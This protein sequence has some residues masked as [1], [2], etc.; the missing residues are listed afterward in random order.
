VKRL[1]FLLF[2]MFVALAQPQAQARAAKPDPQPGVAPMRV[3]IV[4]S[5]EPGCEPYCAEWISA[6]G[7]INAGTPGEFRRAL[8]KMGARN[9]PVF[10]HSGGGLI[11]AALEIGRMLLARKLNI[12]VTGTP[13]RR[14]RRRASRWASPRPS[15]RAALRPARLFWRRAPSGLCRRSVLSACTAPRP[16]APRCA[17]CGDTA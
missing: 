5:D 2:C 11:P 14:G 15:T 1:L 4:R 6:E 12:I 10:I 7:K 16:S 13:A 3:T 9:L 8:Q 17:C